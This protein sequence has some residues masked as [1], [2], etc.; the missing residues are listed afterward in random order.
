MPHSANAPNIICASKETPLCFSVK[1]T[2]VQAINSITGE[3]AKTYCSGSGSVTCLAMNPDLDV[4]VYGDENGLLVAQA[5][6]TGNKYWTSEMKSKPVA[7]IAT[8]VL[9]FICVETG[10]VEARWLTDGDPLWKKNVTLGRP[11]CMEIISHNLVL[12]TNKGEVICLGILDGSII[13]KSAVKSPRSEDTIQCMSGDDDLD[14]VAIGNIGGE[15][16]LRSSC[17][18]EVIWKQE[19]GSPVVSVDISGTRC[20]TGSTSGVVSCWDIENHGELLWQGVAFGRLTEVEIAENIDM[21]LSCGDS[22]TVQMWDLMTGEKKWEAEDSKV[23]VETVEYDGENVI[24]GCHFGNIYYVDSKDGSLKW[25]NDA[26]DEI[27][28]TELS[29]SFDPNNDL[30]GVGRASG[31]ASVFSLASQSHLFNVKS[32]NREITAM[33]LTE[34][35]TAITG[36]NDFSLRCTGRETEHWMKRAKSQPTTITTIGDAVIVGYKDGTCQCLSIHNGEERWGLGADRSKSLKKLDIMNGVTPEKRAKEKRVFGS[37]K[38]NQPKLTQ[39]LE[40]EKTESTPSSQFSWNIHPGES[41]SSLTFDES[42]GSVLAVK[43]H[44]SK[45]TC[46][47]LCLKLN[48]GRPRWQ[49]SF[50]ANVIMNMQLPSAAQTTFKNVGMIVLREGRLLAFDRATGKPKGS[51][52]KSKKIGQIVAACLVG[53]YLIACSKSYI[54]VAEYIYE[55]GGKTES[56]F[57]HLWKSKKIGQNGSIIH[58]CEAYRDFGAVICTGNE[59]LIT[60]LRRWKH[61]YVW[62]VSPSGHEDPI[63]EIKIKGKY[64]Y[65]VSSIIIRHRINYAFNYDGM[66][67]NREVVKMDEINDQGEEGGE[68][69]DNDKNKNKDE[70]GRSSRIEA[71]INHIIEYQNMYE[72]RGMQLLQYG[73]FI[74]RCGFA[75]KN[76][77]APITYEEI[78]DLLSSLGDIMLV[79]PGINYLF[80]FT[81]CCAIVLSFLITFAVQEWVEFRK[82]LE[83]NSKRLH[84]LW[85]FLCVVCEACSGFFAVPILTYLLKMLK[86]EEYDGEFYVVATMPE[87]EEFKGNNNGTEEEDGFSIGEEQTIDLSAGLGGGYDEIKCWEG[88]HLAYSAIGL[89]TCFLY[90]PMA[91][92]FIRVDKKLD[93]IEA[94]ANFFDWKSDTVKLEKR[95]HAYSLI[96]TTAERASFMVGV[97][98]TTVSTFVDSEFAGVIIDFTIQCVFVITTHLHP[99]HFDRKTNNVAILLAWSTLYIFTTAIISYLLDD[100][101]HVLVNVLPL[102]MPLIVIGGALKIYS[103]DVQVRWRTWSEK[104]KNEGGATK[105][106]IW[107]REHLKKVYI[108]RDLSMKGRGKEIKGKLEEAKGFV[109]EGANFLF[110]KN[111][112]L[113]FS[114]FRGK[115]TGKGGGDLEEGSTSSDDDEEDEDGGMESLGTEFGLGL[116]KREGKKGGKGKGKEE[117]EEERKAN[118]ED[119]IRMAGWQETVAFKLT[120]LCLVFSMVLLVSSGMAFF[121]GAKFDNTQYVS[122]MSASWLMAIICVLCNSG[123]LIVANYI[124]TQFLNIL[125]LGA[126]LHAAQQE[127]YYFAVLK[128]GVE[129]LNLPVELRGGVEELQFGYGEGWF[130][131]SNTGEKNLVIEEQC[132][133]GLGGDLGISQCDC[134]GDVGSTADLNVFSVLH[135]GVLFEDEFGHERVEDCMCFSASNFVCDYLMRAD[136]GGVDKS[137]HFYI[138]TQVSFY[139]AVGAMMASMV[140]VLLSVKASLLALEEYFEEANIAQWKKWKEDKVKA[141]KIAVLKARGKDTGGVDGSI[142]GDVNSRIRSKNLKRLRK[143]ISNKGLSNASSWLGLKKKEGEGEGKEEGKEEK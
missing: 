141:L 41:I 119:E 83:P 36:S 90:L 130:N 127:F 117:E 94:K 131:A 59:I 76:I 19:S 124:K 27:E 23:E 16:I 132:P 65:S 128:K 81:G 25:R 125:A 135:S 34:V 67:I 69:N 66:S 123:T 3:Q 137:S 10:R 43:S 52:F 56:P 30:I 92:R 91:V 126:S 74:Q 33:T 32:H 133:I 110:N 86:C 121:Y 63:E 134:C 80:V 7:L 84:I 20:V 99:P 77:D 61:P 87:M 42:T 79:L 108:D 96:D 129:C 139:A 35:S 100:P 62:S 39:F 17:T 8:D 88:N 51:I 114:V 55:E 85:G 68:D 57:R 109:G 112:V 18:D 73:L 105:R 111:E 21:V 72:Y 44:M 71:T 89:F 122:G 1:G 75:F 48:D 113:K 4:M 2:T 143:E 58:S 120:F 136:G 46:T 9:T 29:K 78:S 103:E 98:L 28:C 47:L 106:R 64:L 104:R 40:R 15:V 38:D 6:K 115:G 54:H 101:N 26:D 138:Y 11:M 22:K 70:A 140:I 50:P 12:C 53:D 107:Q 13:Y 24:F 102:L 45:K 118:P 142:L 60:D 49:L 116:R 37:D 82:F 5:S 14:L 97:M 31:L 93:C 95:H